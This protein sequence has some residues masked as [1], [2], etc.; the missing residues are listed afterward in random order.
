VIAFSVQRDHLYL[1]VEA[2]A[3]NALA[4]GVQGREIRIAKSVNRVLGRRGAVWAERYQ[5][6][7][8]TTPRAVR[9]ALVYVPQN[10][11]KHGSDRAGFDP[12]S[13]ARW[14]EGSRLRVQATMS[15]PVVRARRWLARIGW[16][17]HGLLD[18][19]ERPA[20]P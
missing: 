3:G 8:L 12:C 10:H 7:D 11:R 2:E 13:S 4:R 1:L 6:R 18:P 14:F 16:K 15:S 9:N 17:R 5:A 20:G 19:T